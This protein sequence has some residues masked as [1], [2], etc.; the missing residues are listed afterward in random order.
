[1]KWA[2]KKRGR[3]R[4]GY[5]GRERSEHKGVDYTRIKRRR[6]LTGDRPL[7]TG[8]GRNRCGR[9][10]EGNRERV[11]QGVRDEKA[12]RMGFSG[13]E[14]EGVEGEKK[15]AGNGLLGNFL[16]DKELWK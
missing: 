1:M 9:R 15:E 14:K 7:R 5:S 11:T 13:T 10:D 6:K 12:L 8:L 2:V 16:W 4:R 3:G